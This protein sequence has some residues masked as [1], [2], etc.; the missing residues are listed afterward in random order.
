MFFL[1]LLSSLA[2]RGSDAV[3]PARHG[4]ADGADG[5]QVAGDQAVELDA[6]PHTGCKDVK[7]DVIVYTMC[8]ICCNI[9]NIQPNSMRAYP[10]RHRPW[11][12][13]LL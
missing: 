4:V 7:M 6:R 3:L 12:R 2:V 8:S 10:E 1:D 13:L 9:N 11:A 5:A